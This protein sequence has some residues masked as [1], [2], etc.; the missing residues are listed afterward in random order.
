MTGGYPKIQQEKFPKAPTGKGHAGVKFYIRRGKAGTAGTTSAG[1]CRA[2][3]SAPGS[4]PPLTGALRAPSPSSRVPAAPPGCARPRQRQPPPASSS[5]P[6][7]SPRRRGRI[8]PQPKPSAPVRDGHR[9]LPGREQDRAR[10]RRWAR[11]IP[12]N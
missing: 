4:L 11:L 12:L 7:C 1:G 5:V 10:R 8:H 9:G 3:L 2:E 6:G